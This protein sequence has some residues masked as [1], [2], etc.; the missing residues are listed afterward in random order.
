M[1]LVFSDSHRS[2]SEMLQVTGRLQPDLVIHLGDL[3]PDAQQLSR[4]FPALAMVTVPGN[5]DGWTTEP[6]ER[7]I[8]V[9]GKKI[10]LGHGHKWGVKQGYDAAIYAANR[11]NADVLLFG[12]T[13]IP[14]CAQ[15]DSLWVLNPGASPSSYGTITI[16]G[17][18]IRCALGKPY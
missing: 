1:I 18:L 15:H 10:L 7:L 4:A 14:Y 6:T 8:T 3:T 13:H 9:H 5:C 2:C 16:D 17:D 12:H 11:A